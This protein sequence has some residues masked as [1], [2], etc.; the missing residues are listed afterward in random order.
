M[1]WRNREDAKRRRNAKA[2]ANGGEREREKEDVVFYGVDFV[3]DKREREKRE[4]EKRER[5]REL[6]SKTSGH[7]YISRF[8]LLK[9]L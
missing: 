1:P 9:K 2:K 8:P 5:E 6:L 7:L 4:R 3:C